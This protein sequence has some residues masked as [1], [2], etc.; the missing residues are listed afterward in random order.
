MCSILLTIKRLAVVIDCQLRLTYQLNAS[1]K[2]WYKFH[3]NVNL[4]RHLTQDPTTQ[5]TLDLFQGR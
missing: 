2:L 1:I 3:T 5:E 4:R